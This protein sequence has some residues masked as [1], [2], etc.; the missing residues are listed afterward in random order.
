VVTHLLKS[1]ASDIP[2]NAQVFVFLKDAIT[3]ADELLVRRLR[4]HSFIPLPA[5]GYLPASKVF[6]GA[7]PF[8]RWR[9]SLGT[10]LRPVQPLFDRVGIRES[11][12]ARDAIAVL[13]DLAAEFGT[14][15]RTLDEESRVVAL[16]CWRLLSAAL[17]NGSVPLADLEQLSAEKV[18]PGPRGILEHPKALFFED[19]TGLAQRFP[20]LRGSTI[21]RPEGAWPAMATAGVRSLT[22]TV[23]V[24]LVECEGELR[25]EELRQ[26]L[27]TRRAGLRRVLASDEAWGAWNTGDLDRLLDALRC[28]QA[29]T[30][31]ICFEIDAFGR[32]DQSDPE[33]TTAVFLR[34]EQALYRLSRSSDRG[35]A[36]VARELARALD[37]DGE[38]IGTLAA[39]IREVL[40][41]E[42]EQGAAD[43]LDELGYAPVTEIPPGQ[44]GQEIRTLGTDDGPAGECGNV[45]EVSPW[46]HPEADAPAN[47][48]NSASS[49]PSGV[50]RP[51]SR[52]HHS[53]TGGA[54]DDSSTPPGSDESQLGGGPGF[55]ARAGP[56]NSSPERKPEQMRPQAKLRSYVSSGLPSESAVRSDRDEERTALDRAG[57]DLVL[58]Y[59]RESGRL[60]TEMSHTNPGYDV[61]SRNESGEIVRYIEV[62]STGTPWGSRGVALSNV[63]YDFAREHGDEFWLYVVCCPGEESAEMFRIQNPAERVTQYA[64]DDGWR[65]IAD[66]GEPG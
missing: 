1:A 39:G 12:D 60:P 40:S 29:E 65:H 24:H 2:V 31:V 47:S 18:V 16:E 45:E 13:R 54:S 32:P 27:D 55:N 9:A 57:V 15:N 43:L 36:A 50:T 41:A 59:E 33:S 20:R 23:R 44:A 62:K 61:E 22:R 10:E 58:T 3:D 5:G 14:A 19:R 30:L 21:A 35:W 25:D 51:A 52:A 66:H 28:V 7:H 11:P 63:Q 26:R 46:P 8:G 56:S 17:Q 48:A 34:E 49:H 37:A 38:R 64:F 53:R 42:S 6:W 4:A